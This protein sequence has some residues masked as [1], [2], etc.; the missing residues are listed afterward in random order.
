MSETEGLI[1]ENSHSYDEYGRVVAKGDSVSVICA[2]IVNFV[3]SFIRG[4]LIV[5]FVLLRLLV[6][7]VSCGKVKL[8]KS[9]VQDD[10]PDLP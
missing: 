3:T 8:S 2:M 5:L 9:H 1:Q 6:L 7:C 10:M 4:I